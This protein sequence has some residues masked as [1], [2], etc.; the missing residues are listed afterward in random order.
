MQ[1]HHSSIALAPAVTA[2]RYLD[3]VWC[4]SGC[5]SD[6]IT[7]HYTLTVVSCCAL[8]LFAVGVPLHYGHV[9]R[10]CIV[11]NNPQMH[12]H[13]V[14]ASELELITGLSWTYV[15]RCYYLVASF[16]RPWAFFSIWLQLLALG[17]MLLTCL[18]MH[19]VTLTFARALVL[20]VS[21][22]L[23]II[24]IAYRRPYRLFTSNVCLVCAVLCLTFD[25]ISFTLIASGDKSPFSKFSVMEPFL[26]FSN[27]V[28]PSI[29]I[30]GCFCGVAPLR[31]LLPQK[32]VRWPV[33]LDSYEDADS[34]VDTLAAGDA[35]AKQ[36]YSLLFVI[37]IKIKVHRTDV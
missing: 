24:V 22:L 17:W 36:N 21:L 29:I 34:I 30:L 10:G 9:L 18:T 31:L 12:E 14:K 32:L 20:L 8:S 3:A 5:G 23:W 25:C 27:I 11:S 4:N 1:P 35:I 7:V 37:L 19:T 15:R 26:Q 13:N 33:R 28:W 2:A 16:A 6:Y